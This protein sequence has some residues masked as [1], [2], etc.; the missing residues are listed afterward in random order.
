[1]LFYRGV[2]CDTE[3]ICLIEAHESAAESVKGLQDLISGWIFSPKVTSKLFQTETLCFM[4]LYS[5]GCPQGCPAR[6]QKKP[7]HMLI[8]WRSLLKIRGELKIS[9]AIKLIKTNCK[10]K[11]TYSMI[12]FY[13]P[14]KKAKH[15]YS[16]RGGQWLPKT[17]RWKLTE[18][19]AE[20]ASG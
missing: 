13:E 6:H 11:I 3:V 19:G 12:P 4:L 5:E 8:A 17:R 15:I 1:M 10:Q 14:R 9:K 18:K 20:E 16:E 7:C 2:N